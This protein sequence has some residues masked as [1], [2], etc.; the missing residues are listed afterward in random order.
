MN[1]RF[2]GGQGEKQPMMVIIDGLLQMMEMDDLVEI[3]SD[4]AERVRFNHVGPE[5]ALDNT[6]PPTSEDIRIQSIGVPPN[7]SMAAPKRKP[8]S[9]KQK[10][11]VRGVEYKNVADACTKLGY[12]EK[13]A[14]ARSRLNA[15]WT[16]DQA[17]PI[18]WL[19]S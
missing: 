6:P 7:E 1:Q 18:S 10:V 16:A 2:D 4:L 9:K 3:M 15:G 13:A 11:T 12:P 5:M 17:M 8:A 19:N 14:T